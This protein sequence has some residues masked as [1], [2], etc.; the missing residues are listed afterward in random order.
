MSGDFYIDTV[1]EMA[2]INILIDTIKQDDWVDGETTL[3]VCSPEYSSII[4]QVMCHKL[5][6]LRE[7]VPLDLDFLEMPYPG[8]QG[9]SNARYEQL[10]HQFA[11]R[12]KNKLNKLLFVDSG[13]LRGQNFTTLKNII[14]MYI[15]GVLTRYACVYKQ[16]NSIFEPDYYVEDFDFEKD[17][18]LTFWWEDPNNPYWGW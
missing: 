3:V 18:G 14:G 2:D 1:K 4:C 10:I 8:G 15:S 16:R 13:V 7:Y 5:S 12:Y 11:Q 17:G 6:Y 9:L